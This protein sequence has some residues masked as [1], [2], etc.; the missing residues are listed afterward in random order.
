MVRNDGSLKKKLLSTISIWLLICM[1]LLC[2]ASIPVPAVNLVPYNPLP[3]SII[4]G[5]E[6]FTV[7]DNDADATY[8]EFWMDG[9]YFAD[10]RYDGSKFWYYN[11][12]TFALE[13]GPYFIQYK[14]YKSSGLDDVYGF[15]VYIDNNGPELYDFEVT[16]PPPQEAARWGDSVFFQITA[17]DDMGVNFIMLNCSSFNITSP[18][19]FMFDDG[20]HMD[21]QPSDDVYGSDPFGVDAFSTGLFFVNVTA[22][23]NMGNTIIQP[24]LIE[25]DN[26]MPAIFNTNITYPTGQAAASNGDQIRVTAMAFDWAFPNGIL[27][28]MANLAPINGST[29]EPMFDD[30]LHGDGFEGDGMYGSDWVTVGTYTN[31]FVPL[32][33]D[34][35]DIAL[36]RAQNMAVLNQD[37]IAPT[38]M[39]IKIDYPDGKG[40]AEDGDRINVTATMTDDQGLGA[41]T[42]YYL[43][44]SE[45]GGS[46]QMANTSMVR[47]DGIVVSAGFTRGSTS[48]MVH[49]FDHAANEGIMSSHVEVAQEIR[50]NPWVVVTSPDGGENWMDGDHYPITWVAD[51]N[52]GPRPIDLYYSTD[53]GETW[54]PIALDIQNT[55]YYNWTVPTEETAGALIRVNV[56]DMYGF[57]TSDTS[58]AS[59]SIDPPPPRAPSTPS[60]EERYSPTII[61]DPVEQPETPIEPEIPANDG[62]LGTD[63]G[64]KASK[65]SPGI[66]SA[67]P[68]AIA[69]GGLLII[70]IIVLFLR[71]RGKKNINK[72]SQTTQKLKN[73][74]FVRKH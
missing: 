57:N 26:M 32:I 53:N 61:D 19:G 62:K 3:N 50:R 51:G 60:S 59:F 47:W 13:D 69:M 67:V 66:N 63:S 12:T 70:T 28:V 56:S 17:V 10:M 27:A 43:D 74:S 41:L 7:V 24:Y 15:A 71:K 31:G 55:G 5:N 39:K 29:T 64:D 58:D 20:F 21:G 34:A 22:M 52:L 35:Y 9:E 23:D 18:F 45:I 25:I 68:A 72:T 46:N 54:K 8:I 11:L 33:I 4:S 37:N 44:A 6:N 73:I 2:L 40:Y 49:A 65:S 48:V 42:W 14:G 30:G 1:G 16:Y 38:V 36:N